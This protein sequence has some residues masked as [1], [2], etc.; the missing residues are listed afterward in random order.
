MSKTNAW[1]LGV[2]AVNHG[3]VSP[4]LRAMGG[5]GP[6][7]RCFIG[8]HGLPVTRPSRI[9]SDLL[10]VHEDP[11]AVAQIVADAIRKVVDYP[12]TFADSLAP[13]AGHLGLRKGDGL[14]VLGWFLELV[15]DPDAERWM[16]E[17]RFHL[18]RASAREEA[19][20]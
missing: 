9:A 8:R 17:A 14:A 15:G 20:A 7:R 2:G 11:E 12:G 13:H 6:C 4:K 10:W 3:A 5:S 1:L 18:H 16:D 19:A